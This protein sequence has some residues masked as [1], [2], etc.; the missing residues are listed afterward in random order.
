MGVATLYE[1][2]W[3]TTLALQGVWAA[4]IWR[5]SLTRRYPILFPYLC[6]LTVL[7]VIGYTLLAAEVR[8]FDRAAYTLFW[9]YTRPLDW[10]LLFLLI[11]EVYRY[12]LEDYQGLCKLGK[13][14]LYA[15]LM[16]VVVL[17]GAL[18]LIDPFQG[19]VLNR[20]HRFWLILE[21][22]IYLAVAVIVFMLL[23]FKRLFRLSTPRNVHLIFASFGLYFAGQAAFSV[24]RMYMGPWFNGV[25][26]VGSLLLYAFCLGLGAALFSRA[27]EEKPVRR[28]PLEEYTATAQ[29]ASKQLD[30]LNRRLVEALN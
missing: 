1:G 25:S 12:I 7:G 11:F 8:V 4:R 22:D 14:V 30:T 19:A 5:S 15:A 27:G 17:I 18:A 13:W 26:N 10:A 24:L 3:A 6:T 20:W 2:L 21:R 29:A 23:M 28:R 16:G 9:M